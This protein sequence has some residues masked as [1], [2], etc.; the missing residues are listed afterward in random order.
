MPH[1]HTSP[2]Q[3]DMTVSAYIIRYESG[4]YKCLVHFH[5]KIDK[6]MQVGGHIELDENPWQSIAHELTEESGYALGELEILQPYDSLPDGIGSVFHPTPYL[7]NTH[8]VGDGH[9]HSDS[10][11]AFVA[12]A[13]PNNSV[14]DGESQDIR[15]LS[16]K[17]LEASAELGDALRD[18]CR[19]YKHIVA[20]VDQ[21]N[22]VPASSFS[23]EMPASAEISYK[24]G[25]PSES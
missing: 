2:G 6:L 19:I 4:E 25:R 3:R 20:H 13:E 24:C 7:S 18:C 8:S 12:K 16:L 10:C 9:Y 22:R 1:I 11:Y 21:M 15:W 14:A 5:R 23:L 17:E